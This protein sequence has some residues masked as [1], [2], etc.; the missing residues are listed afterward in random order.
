MTRV[1]VTRTHVRN[2]QVRFGAHGDA[3]IEFE[4]KDEQHLQSFTNYTV[5]RALKENSRPPRRVPVRDVFGLV[6][7]VQVIGDTACSRVERRVG[8]KCQHFPR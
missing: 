6:D 1:E 2:V 8:E 7:L 4:M 3:A 5:P